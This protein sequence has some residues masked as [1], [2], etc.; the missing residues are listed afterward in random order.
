[1]AKASPQDGRSLLLHAQQDDGS[2]KP[3]FPMW[4]P[5]VAHEWGGYLTMARL[6]TLRSYGRIA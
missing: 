3:N 1:M 5:L 4:T 2:W 6:K